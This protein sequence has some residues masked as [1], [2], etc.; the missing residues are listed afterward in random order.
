VQAA[1]DKQEITEVIYRYCRGIDRC[2]YALVRSCY[3]PDAIDD[4]GDFR[5]GVDDFIAYVEQGLQRFER[6]MHFIG[7][8]LVDVRGDRARAESYLTAYH[9]LGESRTKPERDFIAWLRYLDDFERR[10]GE[11]KIAARACVFEFS[12]IDPVHPGGWAPAS[13]A[14][15]GRRDTTDLLY[16]PSVLRP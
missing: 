13:T 14:A 15:Q 5:G 11:W 3:H 12:R 4:H 9:H 2:D 6:T 7:N 1:I 16:A 8:V 10:D